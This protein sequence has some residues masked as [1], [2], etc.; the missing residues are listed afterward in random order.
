MDVGPPGYVPERQRAAFSDILPR[1]DPEEHIAALLSGWLVK[2]DI[3]RTDL[4]L[5]LKN[6]E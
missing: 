6:R 4:I 1:Y 3:D 5:A 2:R